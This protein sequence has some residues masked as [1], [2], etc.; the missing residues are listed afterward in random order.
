MNL[1]EKL[2]LEDGTGLADAKTF[3]SLVGGLI[4]LTHTRPDIAFS[5]G[6]V[7]RFKHSPSKHHIGT[8][9][10][11]LHYVAGTVDY[12]ICI[13]LLVVASSSFLGRLFGICF[14]LCPQSVRYNVELILRIL[15]QILCYFPLM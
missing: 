14:L 5:V 2:Q 8:T 9:K 15:D 4:Y 10:R 7:S 3:R 1:N 13:F 11:I 12:G 6:V